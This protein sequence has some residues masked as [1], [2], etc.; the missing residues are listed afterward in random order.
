MKVILSCEVEVL[1][2][3]GLSSVEGMAFDQISKILYFVD[4]SR[5][6]VE[7]VKA[8][9]FFCVFLQLLSSKINTIFFKDNF[10]R[11]IL[12]FEMF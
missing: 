11:G 1:V 6:T 9:I 10:L 12:K 5:R 8:N 2:E 3:A 7:L 4:G